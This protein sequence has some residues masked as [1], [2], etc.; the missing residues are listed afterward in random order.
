M[1]NTRRGYKRKTPSFIW[2]NRTITLASRISRPPVRLTLSILGVLSTA[3]PINFYGFPSPSS[4]IIMIII[5]CNFGY[6]EGGR[7]KG[8]IISTSSGLVCVC[9]RGFSGS[10]DDIVSVI[11]TA[12]SVDSLSFLILLTPPCWFVRVR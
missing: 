6:F 12:A 3:T 10:F 7:T 11:T 2:I 5:E 4:I 9:L 1:R 8:H